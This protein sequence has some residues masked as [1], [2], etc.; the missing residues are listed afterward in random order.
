MKKLILNSTLGI[1]VT[2]TCFSQAVATTLPSP[3]CQDFSGTLLLQPDVDANY[4]PACQILQRPD[5]RVYFSDLLKPYNPSNLNAIQNKFQF[6]AALG[7][8]PPSPPGSWCFTGT[9]NGTLDGQPVTGVSYSG[10]TTNNFPLPAP[11]NFPIPN[12]AATTVVLYTKPP[13]GG[14]YPLGNIYFRDIF[15]ITDSSGSAKEQLVVI[16]ASG[17]FWGIKGTLQIE[18][19]EFIPPGATLVGQFC[20]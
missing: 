4:H 8:P 2:L 12:S 14:G 18:G 1:L 20:R 11:G 5:T 17:L 15:F 9:I 13:T 19:N 6:L 10:Q 3:L 7:I 16:G